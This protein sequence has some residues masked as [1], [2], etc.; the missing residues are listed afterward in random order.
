MIPFH[1]SK[2]P[3]THF[4]KDFI[5]KRLKSLPSVHW[6][7]KQGRKS[8]IFV[9]IS[10]GIALFVYLTAV[11]FPIYTINSTP[12]CPRGVY[13]NLPVW[14][15]SKNDYVTVTCPKTYAPLAEEGQVL[16]KRVK[17]MPGDTYRVLPNNM[18]IGKEIF[19]I[20][21]LDYLPQ[22]D[23]GTYTVP[24]GCYLF[25]NDM[26]YSFDSRYMGP[27][28]GDHILHKEI[29][30]INLDFFKAMYLRLTG[31]NADETYTFSNYFSHM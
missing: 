28:S 18:E 10:F 4:L 31:G 8:K 6:N 2:L 30:L 15:L 21:Q 29:L 9:L 1:T 14:F 25:L 7:L 3:T 16:I 26:P 12:S 24:D 5:V 23:V 17:A 11:V 20:Y 22:L 19:P 27:I 13:L